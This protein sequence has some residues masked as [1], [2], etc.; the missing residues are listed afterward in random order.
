[1]P[2][3]HVPMTANLRLILATGALSVLTACASTTAPVVYPSAGKAA[4]AG[5]AAPDAQADVAECRRQAKSAVGV[6]DLHAQKVASAGGKRGAVEFVDRAVE[7]LVQR[8]G[9][10]WS[11]ARGAAA[12]VVAGGLTSVALNWNEPD[13][14]YREFV[15][16]CMKE[17]GHKVLGW[18]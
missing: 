10:V 12:G 13:A 8:S 17:R 5:K 1:M 14:V 11:K 4:K 6:N 15:E 3:P 16:E 9:E 18:R 7:Q 2:A